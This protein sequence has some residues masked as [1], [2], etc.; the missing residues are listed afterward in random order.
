MRTASP[1]RAALLAGLHREYRL[2]SKLAD[3]LFPRFLA[4][5]VGSA[6][7]KELPRDVERGARRFRCRRSPVP[8]L[9]LPLGC[10]WCLFWR[11]ASLAVGLHRRQ[12][13]PRAWPSEQLQVT[14]RRYAAARSVIFLSRIL[15][16]PVASI[17]LTSA[18]SVGLREANV[19]SFRTIG[20]R[21]LIR[22]LRSRTPLARH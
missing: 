11:S 9:R 19:S 22:L 12:V 13:A 10:W 14:I 1:P 4:A 7:P 5:I 17:S 2:L 20:A 3:D 6:V 18:C 16:F 21:Y 15:I 8:L